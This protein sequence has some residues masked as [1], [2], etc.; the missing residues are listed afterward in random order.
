M[1]TIGLSG[2]GLSGREY[3]HHFIDLLPADGAPVL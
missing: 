3:L 2:L 1:E